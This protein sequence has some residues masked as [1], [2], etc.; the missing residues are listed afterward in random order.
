M[1]FEIRT[2]AEEVAEFTRAVEAAF[3]AHAGAEELEDAATLA[4]PGRVLGVFENGRVVGGVAALTLELT[5]PGAA[6]VPA[7]GVTQA[8]VLP[9]HRRRGLFTALHARQLEDCRERGEVVTVLTASEGSIYSRFGY[10]PAVLG[11]AA[12]LDPARAGFAAPPDRSGSVRLL[13]AEEAALVLPQVF[14]RYRREQPGEVS[15]SP[16]YWEVLLRDRERDREGFGPR[17]AVVHQSGD[18]VVDGYV[19]YRVRPQWRM[20]EPEFAL[21][22]EEVV[23]ADPAVRAALWR[24]VLDVDL[25]AAVTCWNLPLD[26]PLRWLLADHRGLRVT[27]ISDVLWV[28]LLDVPGALAARRYAAEGRVVLE[29]E[30]RFCPANTGR[31]VLQAG[32]EGAECQPTSQLPDLVLAIDALATA[33]LGGTRF[34]TLARGGRVVEHR[35]GALATAD[36]LFTATPPPHCI[37]DF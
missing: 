31:Y 15:R 3:G 8:G 6:A 21:A 10:G 29:V 20:N 24:Y 35:P 9:T 16:A 34:V 12:E 25:V 28:R 11:L 27:G 33:F 19:T 13:A 26:E 30:D 36:A 1:D 22:V 4:E 32:R 7:G 5:L 14:D 17:F 18:G 23:T 2:V 37:T